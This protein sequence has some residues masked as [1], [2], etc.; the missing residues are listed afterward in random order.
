V[1]KVIDEECLSELTLIC[2]Q[3]FVPSNLSKKGLKLIR[4]AKDVS[5][6]F[7]VLSTCLSVI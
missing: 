1:V 3:H 4:N 7:T 5:G 2:I 6:S